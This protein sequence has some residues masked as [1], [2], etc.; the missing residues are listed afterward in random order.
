MSVA[1]SST[2]LMPGLLPTAVPVE[3]EQAPFISYIPAFEHTGDASDRV[4]EMNHHRLIKACN[5]LWFNPA[6]RADALQFCDDMVSHAKKA[7]V[8]IGAHLDRL[9]ICHTHAIQ[10]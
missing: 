1:S 7:Q 9:T 3:D 8:T 2:D 10:A 4:A 6:I 5:L